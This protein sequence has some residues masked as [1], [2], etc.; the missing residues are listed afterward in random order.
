MIAYNILANVNADLTVRGCAAAA[1]RLIMRMRIG[2]LPLRMR[3][4]YEV[5]GDHL[6]SNRTNNILCSPCYTPKHF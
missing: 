3:M 6:L 4:N 1:A 2:D 5:Y